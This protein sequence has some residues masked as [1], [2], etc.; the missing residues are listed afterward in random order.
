M[1]ESSKMVVLVPV[2]SEV[3][4][5]VASLHEAREALRRKARERRYLGMFRLQH[6]E[7]LKRYQGLKQKLAR[8]G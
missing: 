1:V 3:D 5:L 8:K 4:Q 7:F 6:A 2:F